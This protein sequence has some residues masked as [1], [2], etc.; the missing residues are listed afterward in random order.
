MCINIR[1]VCDR[2]PH[3]DDGS[4]EFDD[5]CLGENDAA[6]TDDLPPPIEIVSGSM[7]LGIVEVDED[8]KLVLPDDKQG[9]E[10]EIGM[11]IAEDGDR[12]DDSAEDDGPEVAISDILIDGIY[13]NTRLFSKWREENEAVLIAYTECP[14]A[15]GLITHVR[16]TH[17]SDAYSAVKQSVKQ[18]GDNPRSV[19]PKHLL[20]ACSALNT[21]IGE[22]QN[23]LLIKWIKHCNRAPH[24]V[25]RPPQW[26]S[27]EFNSQLKF[28]KDADEYFEEESQ[29]GPAAE[30]FARKYAG[31]CPASS[32]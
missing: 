18:A 21:C 17:C 1:N 12:E 8:G 23:K 9:A 22:P 24:S 26:I 20:D 6:N 11:D 10:D 19:V 25:L 31:A 7:G 5:V 4:D 28:C 16:D 2:H 3:C 30:K 29:R 27:G 15:Y 13:L 14:A 32:P